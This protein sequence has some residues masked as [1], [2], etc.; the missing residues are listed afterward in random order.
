MSRGFQ[1]RNTRLKCLPEAC[2]CPSSTSTP[3]KSRVSSVH[4]QGV[5]AQVETELKEL[6]KLSYKNQHSIILYP[7]H[8][9]FPQEAMASLFS[10]GQWAHP[11]NIQH[12]N[13]IM[14]GSAAVC[15]HYVS[16]FWSFLYCFMIL[17]IYLL[18]LFTINKNVLFA[19][20]IYKQFKNHQC[21]QHP[22]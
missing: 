14:F 17:N 18:S 8:E 20:I 10:T 15:P 9:T 3:W 5:L 19:L 22:E 2:P 1:L 11:V 12:P 21:S 7:L 4:S 13:K 6:E 16:L